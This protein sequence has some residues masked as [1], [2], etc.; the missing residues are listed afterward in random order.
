VTVTR[1]ETSSTGGHATVVRRYLRPRFEFGPAGRAA[2]SGGCR[3]LQ[4]SGWHSDNGIAKLTHC[5]RPRRP[6]ARQSVGHGHGAVAARVNLNLN[7]NS[8]AANSAG[9]S[10]AGP[11]A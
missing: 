11:G 1:A 4:P 9:E 10:G 8:C 6:Q 7:L 5:G 3:A 2:G